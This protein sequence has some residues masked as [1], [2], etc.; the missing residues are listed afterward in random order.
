MAAIRLRLLLAF[1]PLLF[2]TTA[3]S[4]SSDA[5]HLLAARSALFDPS[6][7]LAGLGLRP[8]LTVPLGS[9]FLRQE[10]HHRRY[11]L[12]L[13]SS[14]S[15]AAPGGALLLAVPGAPRPLR[16]RVRGPAAG[17]PR[18][19]PGA[20]A[21]QPR[22]EQLLRRGSGGVGRRV[23]VAP[24]AEPG[25]NL[26]S[27]DFPAFLANI[28]TLQEFSLAYNRFAPSPLPESLGDLADLRVLFVATAPSTVS[29][30]LHWKA[31][32]SRQ[33]DLSTNAIGG[34]IPPSIGNLS[35]LEQIELFA[36]QLSGS[37]RWGLEAS[38]SSVHWNISMNQLH[39]EIPRTCAIPVELG[40]AG[41]WD[42]GKLKK[43][44]Q[45]YL[46]DNHLSGNVPP[47]LGEIIEMNTLDLSNN[48]LSRKYKMNAAELDDGKSNWVLTS[49]HRVDFSEKDIVN[50]LDENNVIGQGGAGKVYKTLA[51]Q[52]KD[53]MCKVLK[54][55]LLCV[56]NLPTRR[57]PMRAVVKMLLEVKEEN[58]LKVEP[59]AT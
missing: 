46:S 48:E 5:E 40:H 1:L 26:L 43:L 56:S 2:Q 30:L 49:Y 3:T 15:A 55:A 27:G 19:A 10:L 41:H 50:S 18:R 9:R 32:E 28:T 36:N 29:S 25:P 58:K 33:S 42:F 51:E 45:L 13:S 31:K 44:S 23:P 17:M 54:I 6:D 52:F 57:P 7:A 4:S 34:E 11:G 12:D 20:H 35:S 59:L 22:R 8:P 21:P 37:I 39:W 16:E 38:R 14:S 53:E 47:E 24:R